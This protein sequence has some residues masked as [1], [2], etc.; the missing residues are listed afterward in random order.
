MPSI[1]QLF[2]QYGP[3]YRWLATATAMVSAVAVGRQLCI[4]FANLRS[5]F[6]SRGVCFDNPMATLKLASGLLEGQDC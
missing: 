5:R 4:S 6:G 2:E 1:S 3:A